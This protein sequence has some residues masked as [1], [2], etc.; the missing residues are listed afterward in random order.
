[1]PTYTQTQLPMAVTTPLGPDDLLLVGLTGNEG[2][3][4]LFSFTLELLATNGTDVPFDKLLGQ[5][6]SVR[7]NLADGKKRFFSGISNRISQGHTDD[8]FTAYQMEVV[9]A[10]WLWTKRTQSRIFQHVSVP[11]ILKTVLKGLDASYEIQGT[12]EP[13]DYCVQYRESDFNFATR[14]MEEEGMYYYFKH[15][16][17]GHQ[18]VIANTPVGHADLPVQSKLIYKRILGGEQ[19]VEAIVKEWQKVQE[20]T[21]GKVTLWDH[22]F[23]LP[24]K[25]VEADKTIQET[26]T[27]GQLNH[28][29]KVAN[30]DKLEIYDYP[31]AYA[32]RFDGIAPGGGE[33]PADVQKIFDDNKRTVGI[34]MQEEAAKGV[35]IQAASTCRQ[36]TSGHKFTLEL[37]PGEVLDKARKLEGTYVLLSVE[38][39]AHLGGHYRSGDGAAAF[40]YRNSFTCIPFALPYRPQRTTYK[41]VVAGSQTAVVVGPAGEEI[42]TDKYSRVKVQFHWDREG[43]NNADSSC[44]IRVATHWAGKQWGIIHIPRIGQ[45][46]VVDFLEGDPD[47]PI[48][49]GS[50]YNAET[51]PPYTL[52]A[53][54]TQS[55]IKTRSSMGGNPETF[56]EICFEDKKGSELL[57]IR[58]EKDHTVGVEN[59]E[60]HWVGNDRMKT[61]DH[62]ETTLVHHDRTETVD[63]NET[64]TVHGNRTET[65]DKN[66]TITIH[67]NRTETVDQNETITV[68]GNRTRTVSKNEAIT[69]TLARTHTVGI[70]EAI[71][72]GAA[73]EVT[74]GAMRTLT[75][76]AAQVTT[77]GATHTVT[78]GAGQTVSIGAN[79]SISVGGNLSESVGGNYEEKVAKSKKA[80]IGEDMG[81]QVG[82]H[83]SVGAGEEIVLKTGEAELIMKKDGTIQLKGK[84]ITITGSGKITGKAG[85]DMVLKG[86]SKITLN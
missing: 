32:Q 54:K 14:L 65:V 59:D 31:G 74:V 21:S 12:F 17:K 5:P 79:Q 80:D 37:A 2:V 6:I 4:Q 24:H 45:E 52:P 46:V 75:V 10:F 81:T 9:P 60:S 20:L 83:F 50:V 11:D 44:W 30:N 78:V 8:T 36:L 33:K 61:I 48:I 62:D 67:Q 13:H 26:V 55:G 7:L 41:P 23:E 47:Q 86:G 18:L 15:S 43:K 16:D 25:H 68:S 66:E 57:Y 39:S 38:H 19:T 28:K 58:A 82:K 72:V 1:M 22:C 29:L 35:L 64:I 56:N 34:R 85:G 40:D 42:F 73:Q 53:N 77:I 84:D 51:M 71:T 49:V 27:V 3:S 63:N 70:N 76:G 69:V